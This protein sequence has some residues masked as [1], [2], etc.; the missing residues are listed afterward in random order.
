LSK[1]EVLEGKDK[2]S[3]AKVALKEIIHVANMVVEMVTH[4]ATASKNN[5]AFPKR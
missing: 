2:I 3:E 4:I 1:K 5:P